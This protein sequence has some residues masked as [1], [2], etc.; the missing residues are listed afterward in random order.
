MSFEVYLQGEEDRTD[1]LPRKSDLLRIFEGRVLLDEAPAHPVLRV[2]DATSGN[3]ALFYQHGP[4]D[5]LQSHFM[6][7]RPLAAE[8]LWDG[9]L[10]LLKT[11]DLYMFWPSVPPHFVTARDGVPMRED[12]PVEFRHR[13]N[14]RDELLQ[15]MAAS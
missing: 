14:S 7:E 9:L 13:V 12:L 3:S 8:W 5:P 2:G 4:G 15:L 10:R 1:N 11:Y 6:V